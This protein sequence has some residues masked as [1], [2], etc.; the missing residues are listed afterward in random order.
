[1]QVKA[2]ILKNDFVHQF[3]FGRRTLR[4]STAQMVLARET[5]GVA[6]M[7][8]RSRLALQTVM[9]ERSLLRMFQDST[10]LYTSTVLHPVSSI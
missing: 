3:S 10:T 4:L 5:T 1:M 9:R 7:S 2:M 8:E 6:R